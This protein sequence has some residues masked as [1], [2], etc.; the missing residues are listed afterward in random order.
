M[1]LVG[2]RCDSDIRCM[3][4]GPI[5]R[6]VPSLSVHVRSNFGK[7]NYFLGA[8]AAKD[9]RASRYPNIDF[10][11]DP[12]VICNSPE[13]K[14]LKWIA[15]MFYWIESVQSY[16]NEGWDYLTE[17][18]AFVEGGMSDT[19]FIDGVS[20]IVNRGCHDPPC[21][22][23]AVD[24]SYERSDNFRKVLNTFFQGS[25]P[26]VSM[27]EMFPSETL[28]SEMILPVDN[29]NETV[30][31]TG[32][33]PTVSQSVEISLNFSG[34]S[35]S[36]T[37]STVTTFTSDESLGAMINYPISIED[38]S[39]TSANTEGS[40]PFDENHATSHDNQTPK[41]ILVYS[42]GDSTD[43]RI[44]T[45]AVD[46]PYQ[47]DLFI[48]RKVLGKDAVQ[49][50]KRKIMQDLGSFLGC[51]ISS[52]T[53]LRKMTENGPIVGFQSVSNEED[54]SEEHVFSP[55]CGGSTK[56]P[57]LVCIS[58][59][60]RL[61][62]FID[63]NASADAVETSTNLI[64][65]TIEDGMQND[66]YTSDVV[67]YVVFSGWQSNNST[68]EESNK[69]PNSI[70]KSDISDESSSGTPIWIPVFVVIIIL[71]V[72]AVNL[73]FIRRYRHSNDSA[74]VRSHPKTLASFVSNLKNIPTPKMESSHSSN[75]DS[76]DASHL[77]CFD[78]LSG[79]PFARKEGDE[80][81]VSNHFSIYSNSDNEHIDTRS[82]QENVVVYISSESSSL[83]EIITDE[84]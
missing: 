38:S 66:R 61:T 20:G 58:A 70:Q 72:L 3:P 13:Y 71:I 39:I 30:E 53:R 6:V 83:C 82:S 77:D 65:S 55:S 9:G 16:N 21:A 10:C 60:S 52:L 45:V 11:K 80:P 74:R 27:Q 59:K 57:M 46:I 50:V 79:P 5:M 33:Y 44:N 15:G 78:E 43:P 23:G 19:S 37:T 22:T 18:R 36:T 63:H 47:Y 68:R 67:R 75:S 24:G 49:E 32:A 4:I 12:E 56:D 41:S 2:T 25:P 40:T 69:N 31:P 29:P 48:S 1:L 35:N 81:S 51:N 76:I 84:K 17:L 73:V 34:T 14:E 28:A 64:L 62:A 7:L 42:C 8:G 26:E 54:L